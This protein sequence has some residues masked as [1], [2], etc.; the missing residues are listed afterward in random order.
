MSKETF[1]T[2]EA[3]EELGVSA[4]RIRQMVLAGELPAEKF[5]RDLVITRTAIE[6]ARQRKTKPGP[7]PKQKTEQQSKA[8]KEGRKR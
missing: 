5:G 7:A 2:S 1:T 6:A 8:T 3:A 4:A